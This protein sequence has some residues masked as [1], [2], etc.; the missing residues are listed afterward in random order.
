MNFFK[1][2]DENGNAVKVYGFGYDGVDLPEGAIQITE[3]ECRTILNE[4]FPKKKTVSELETE[5]EELREAL[6]VLY[7]EGTEE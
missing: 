3:S 7:G 1:I 2:C 5:N 4:L 6:A